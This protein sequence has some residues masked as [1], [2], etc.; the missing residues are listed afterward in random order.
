[1]I[2]ALYM[3]KNSTNK[4]RAHNNESTE[5]ITKISLKQ[6]CVLS[7]VLDDALR[8]CKGKCKSIFLEFLR[9]KTI[10]LQDMLF[11]D[12][13]VIVAETEKKLQHNVNEYQKE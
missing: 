3:Y 7:Q 8:R 12:D 2:R 11:A 9:I 4:V 10:K 5:F 1:M 13:L 6:G